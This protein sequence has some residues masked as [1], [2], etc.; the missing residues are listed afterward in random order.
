ML[1][2]TDEQLNQLV[3]A[4]MRAEIKC[5]HRPEVE[6]LLTAYHAMLAASPTHR[7]V[8]APEG[9]EISG[10]EGNPCH[11]TTPHFFVYLKPIPKPCP[12]PVLEPVTFTPESSYGEWLQTAIIASRGWEAVFGKV[13]YL[14]LS[15]FTHYIPKNYQPEATLI[16]PDVSEYYRICLRKWEPK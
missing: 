12:P 3:A 9:Y 15:G 1:K 4:Y 11:T 6:A 13:E 16:S 10:V 7:V 5:G 8:E 14:K 2:L